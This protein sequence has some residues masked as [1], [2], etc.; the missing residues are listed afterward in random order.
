MTLSERR[1]FRRVPM[2]AQIQ[3]QA[4]GAAYSVQAENIS[5]G[6]VLIRTKDTLEEG[7]VVQLVFTLPGS[8]Q[9]IR[10][11]GKVLHVSPEAFMGVQFESLSPHDKEAIEKFVESKEPLP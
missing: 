4:G 10:A 5:V 1:K 3:A 6:G 8:K 11:K 7:Q 9:E 2:P